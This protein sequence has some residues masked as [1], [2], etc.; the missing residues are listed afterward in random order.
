MNEFLGALISKDSAAILAFANAN[1]RLKPASESLGVHIETL[2]RRLDSIYKRTK[3][4]PKNFWDLL[5]LVKV[6]EDV[7]DV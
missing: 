7:S 1:M 4:N 6:V 3:L 2:S 5:V